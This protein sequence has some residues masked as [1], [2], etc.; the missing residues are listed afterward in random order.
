MLGS[1]EPKRD[2]TTSGAAD[3][4]S[5]ADT[6]PAATA[7]SEALTDANIVALLDE[8]NMADSAAGAYALTKATNADVKAFAKLMMGEH[9]ALRAQ[10]QQLAQRLNV[11]P[12]LTRQRPTQARC[13]KRD[14]SAQGSP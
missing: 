13:R 14:G 2:S 10:G 6:A 3:T 7:G 9:H 12:T 11:T 1:C 8:A 5:R 4:L